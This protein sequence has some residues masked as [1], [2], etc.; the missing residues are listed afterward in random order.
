MAKRFNFTYELSFDEK[1]NWTDIT[2]FIDSRQTQIDKPAMSGEFKSS[3]GTCSFQVSYKKGIGDQME[4]HAALFASLVEAK[5]SNS[6][7]WFHLLRNNNAIF[8]GTVD[9]SGLSQD[10][11]N[12]P[13]WIQLTAYNNIRLLDENMKTAFEFCPDPFL[14][15]DKDG[16]EVVYHSDDGKWYYKNSTI[17]YKGTRYPMFKLDTLWPVFKCDASDVSDD[18]VVQILLSQGWELSDINFAA[19]EP[20]LASDGQSLRRS[21]APYDPGKSERTARNY[22]DSLLHDNLAYLT[23][24]GDGRFVVKRYKM[25]ESKLSNIKGIARY[26]KNSRKLNIGGAIWNK[27]GIK[28]TWASLSAMKAKV[29]DASFSASISYGTDADGNETDELVQGGYDMPGHTYWPE[30]GDLEEVWF[31]FS[32]DWLDRQYLCHITSKRNEDMMLMSTKNLDIDAQ[33]EPDIV[34]AE[35]D[36]GAS[37]NPT[38]MPLRMRT[39]FYNNSS[40]AKKFTR[41][42]VYA[43][44]LYRAK[45]NTMVCP[46]MSEDYDEYTSEFI[47][48]EENA[49]EYARG[50]YNLRH[51]GSMVYKWV[52]KEEVN[53]GDIWIVSPRDTNISTKVFVTNVTITFENGET[54]Y[55]VDALGVSAYNS[56]PLAKKSI[57]VGATEASK[58]D[59]GDSS[60]W[61]H[62]TALWGESTA[63][64]AAGNVDDYYLND[65]T[66]N[67]YRCITSGNSS[68][69]LWQYVGCIKG[70]AAE[71]ENMTWNMEYAL[72]TSSSEI[73]FE[74]A[75]GKASDSAYGRNGSAYGF[76]NNIWSTSIGNWYK[77]LYVWER[78]KTTKLVGYDSENNPVYEITYS[79][80][81]YN[82]TM[83][84]SLLQSC[85]L[86]VSTDPETFVNH[87]RKTNFQYIALRLISVGYKG[88][89]TIT[90]DHGIFSH[91]VEGEYIDG[92]NSLT[93]AVEGS[94]SLSGYYI[95]LPYTL[96]S[97]INVIASLLDWMGDSYISETI[98]S[99]SESRVTG[100]KMEAVDTYSELPD[101]ATVSSEEASVGV[102]DY[103]VKGDYAL[104]KYVTLTPTEGIYRDDAG[105]VQS[106]DESKTYYTK[107]GSSFVKAVISSFDGTTTYYFFR[108][109]P[110]VYNGSSWVRTSDS[111]IKVDT[112][113]DAVGFARV[114]Y[115]TDPTSVDY[116]DCLYAHEALI[117]NLTVGILNV[118]DVFARNIQSYK[119]E[120][121]NGTP[122]EGYRLEYGGS[123]AGNGQ[124]KSVG[125]LFKD[126]KVRGNM[127]LRNED[128]TSGANI[129]HPAL[130]T[131]EGMPADTTGKLL[132]SPSRWTYRELFEGISAQNSVLEAG[133]GSNVGGTAVYKVVKL[134]DPDSVMNAA[135]TGSSVELGNGNT[136]TVFQPTHGGTVTITGT[137]PKILTQIYDSAYASCAL[138]FKDSSGNILA[139]VA[140]KTHRGGGTFDTSFTVTFSISSSTTIKCTTSQV[141]GVRTIN[142][143]CTGSVAAQSFRQA[144]LT[145]TGLWMRLYQGVSHP[146]AWIRFDIDTT[147]PTTESYLVSVESTT[148][149]STDYVNYAVMSKF[150]GY[151]SYTWVDSELVSHTED[152]D[153]GKTYGLDPTLTTVVYNGVLTTV[154][155]ATFFRRDSATTATLIFSDGTIVYFSNTDYLRMSG[156][157][158]IGGAE[159]GVEM[160]GQYPKTD[161]TYD[162]GTPEKRWLTGYISNLPLTSKRSEKKD[163]VPLER[164]ALEIIAG[165]DVVRF[166]FIKDKR[167]TP[168][169]GFIADD[170]DEDLAGPN[171]D[172]MMVNNCIGVLIKAVQELSAEIER[173]K[174]GSA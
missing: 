89:I 141:S 65:E 36:G 118:G 167:N 5:M 158:A 98:I 72:S 139:T 8:T 120:E 47:F 11:S 26:L 143:H 86:E 42:K 10:V 140:S 102:G 50:M 32:S 160:M 108:I 123:G 33:R 148:Y 155:T 133:S 45:V 103:V 2:G 101:Y 79:D 49:S 146:A 115:D 4:R 170:T 127:D 157:I 147:H 73:V 59:K 116:H 78:I 156:R 105:E 84:E 70:D 23:T 114:M 135:E 117:D 57:S 149:E 77:G 55:T 14:Y 44:C 129:L 90:T 161:Q 159:N 48:S 21:F 142:G 92:E 18:I 61:K 97:D 12:R 62:G 93:V 7:V 152:I 58:G 106:F 99:C 124:I 164:S 134:T 126:M 110:Y 150:T 107:S 100:I 121:Q 165:V 27:D 80:P 22:L 137:A 19:S 20:I 163:I 1:V 96:N 125:G 138:T 76:F 95:K 111:A 109:Y 174:G 94:M 128:G 83:T 104:V 131:V 37:D 162:I 151:T 25:T 172:S 66:M 88:T 41:Y 63:R 91:L 24:D 60:I 28:L 113:E 31:D 9:L 6:R 3:V 29:Y 173:L 13:E 82:S 34:L 38:I 54:W 40:A 154:R 112:V 169:I 17:E 67:L 30:T 75:F 166:K 81:L 43:D 145:Q 168:L 51:Y 52:Q 85:R 122:V 136:F 53:P 16:N 35:L 39:L 15:R 74:G 69:A 87:P 68:T 56:E 132:D 46:E 153:V 144:G 119:Y 171:H 71:I 64:G 130:S